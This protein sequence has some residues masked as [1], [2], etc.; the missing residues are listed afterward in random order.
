MNRNVVLAAAAVAAVGYGIA[1]WLARAAVYA[2]RVEYDQ[3]CRDP[4]PAPIGS[5]G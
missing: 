5:H 3:F 4:E 1:A 2:E